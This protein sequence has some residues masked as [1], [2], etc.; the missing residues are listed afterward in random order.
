MKSG[1]VK[2]EKELPLVDYTGKLENLF[3]SLKTSQWG[4]MGV[5]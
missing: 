2:W 1:I 3:Q 4:R 5:C